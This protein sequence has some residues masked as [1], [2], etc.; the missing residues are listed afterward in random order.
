MTRFKVAVCAVTLMVGLQL[1]G[2]VSAFRISKLDAASRITYSSSPTLKLSNNNDYSETFDPFNKKSDAFQVANPENYVQS[3]SVLPLLVGMATF[4]PA[5]AHAAASDY[6][7][8]AG[9]TASLMHPITNFALFF[10]T[11]YSG[12]LGLQWRRQ[13]DIGEQLKALT[14]QLPKLSTGAVKSPIADMVNSINKDISALQAAGTDGNADQAE[15]KLKALRQDLQLLQSSAAVEIDQQIR[16]L[17][18]TRKSLVSMNLR[19]KHHLTGSILLGV[20][21]T[22]S[23]LGAFNTYMR[24]GKLFPGPHLYAGMGIT[25]C[26]AGRFSYPPSLY[27]T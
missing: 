15:Y 7:I 2:S 10:T 23:V 26:W 24:A 22:V 17:T 4:E 25:I 18:A 16:E 1:L 27:P 13:R 21:V 12:Y 19:D 6:G 11:L 3:K 9:R 5:V 20:G 14:A 8:F